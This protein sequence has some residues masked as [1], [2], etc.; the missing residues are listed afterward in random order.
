MVL[1][2]LSRELCSILARNQQLHSEYLCVPLV[3]AI[4]VQ[5]QYGLGSQFVHVLIT[6]V[7][8]ALVNIVIAY[9]SS[10]TA[11]CECF[12][13]DMV[14]LQ[15]VV[16]TELTLGGSEFDIFKGLCPFSC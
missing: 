1:I 6:G 4:L 16:F 12:V 15:A 13:F 8:V 5:I 14:M 9:R 11:E 10:A 3:K 7:A 2:L